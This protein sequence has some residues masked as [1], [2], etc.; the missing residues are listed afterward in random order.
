[1][2]AA[3]PVINSSPLHQNVLGNS[4]PK[5]TTSR[6]PI[7]SW[8]RYKE[9]DMPEKNLTTAL[10]FKGKSNSNKANRPEQVGSKPKPATEVNIIQAVN[11]PNMIL[12]TR[13]A[14][15]K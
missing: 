11:K 8:V 3:I 2:L 12:L 7:I 4:V 14:K 9:K 6:L 15:Y 10:F 1:M 5:Y 13:P